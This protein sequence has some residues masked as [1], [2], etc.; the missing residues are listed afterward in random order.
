MTTKEKISKVIIDRISE[1]ATDIR[2]LEDLHH[3]VGSNISESTAY[4]LLKREDALLKEILKE[5]M[6][7]G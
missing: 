6:S 4:I 2:L 3:K 7:I 5:V 1:V